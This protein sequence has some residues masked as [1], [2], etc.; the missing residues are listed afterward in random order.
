MGQNPREHLAIFPMGGSHRERT[1]THDDGRNAV[2]ARVGAE[3]IPGNLGIVMRVVV[4]DSGSDHQAIRIQDLARVSTYF[5]DVCDTA[6]AD[7]DIAMESRQ[8]GTVNNITVLDHQIVCHCSSYGSRA[9]GAGRLRAN[10][11]GWNES[12]R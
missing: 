10:P 4:D 12:I 3:W 7:G 6:A 8:A 2:I 1:V 5:A 9:V 11:L